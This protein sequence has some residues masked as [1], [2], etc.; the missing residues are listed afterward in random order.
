MKHVDET[1]QSN[2]SAARSLSRG[3]ESHKNNNEQHDVL[4]YY[5]SDLPISLTFGW[6]FA[7]AIPPPTIVVNNHTQECGWFWPSGSCHTCVLTS[8][9]WSIHDEDGGCPDGFS[10]I[11]EDVPMNCTYAQDTQHCCI[12][13]VGESR[14]ECTNLLIHDKEKLCTFVDDITTCEWV[15]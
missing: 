4:N 5:P 15:A 12:D 11:G 10:F 3:C 2:D 13:V 9:D 14:G 1:N 7:C 8:T 6:Q